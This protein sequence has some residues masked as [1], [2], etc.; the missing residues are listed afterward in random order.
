MKNLSTMIAVVGA[1]SGCGSVEVSPATAPT[2]ATTATAP[3]T[4]TTN[5][6]TVAAAEGLSPVATQPRA[7]DESLARLRALEVFTVGA[8]Q[9][10]EPAEAFNCY[11]PC[12]GSEV[13]IARAQAAGAARLD[14]FTRAAEVAARDTAADHANACEPATIAANL[15]AL[16]ALRVVEVGDFLAA[17]PREAANCYGVVCPGEAT[18]VRNESC[19]R[20]EHLA[21]IV[22]ATRG[23]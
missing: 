8:M 17:Q 20:A 4:T 21:D 7:V 13:A 10:Q 2:N 11:G 16:R 18:R 3:T 1:L 15:D 23:M 12:P 14:A 6:A 9:W 5:S 22:D 19:A